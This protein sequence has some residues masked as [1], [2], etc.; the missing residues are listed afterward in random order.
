M[1]AYLISEVAVL[2]QGAWQRYGEL[3]APTIAKY[4]GTYLVRRA[5]PEVAEGDWAPPDA[6]GHEVMVAEFPSL[7]LLHAWYGSPECAE[8]LAYRKTAVS[9][10]LLFVRGLDVPDG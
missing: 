1:T 8:A 10:R 2:D 3:A 9:R 7:D 5:Q 4:G 6:S